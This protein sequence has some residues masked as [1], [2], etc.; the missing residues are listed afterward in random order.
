MS[1]HCQPAV[2]QPQSKTFREIGTFQ[3]TKF[4]EDTFL[5]RS[6]DTGAIVTHPHLHPFPIQIT[7]YLDLPVRR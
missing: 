7:T 4:I 3:A 5:L 6:R 2:R 1:L